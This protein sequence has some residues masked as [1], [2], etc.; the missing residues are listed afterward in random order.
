MKHK[1]ISVWKCKG[2]RATLTDVMGKVA[3]ELG[4]RNCDVSSGRW[5]GG[6]LMSI[7]CAL[8]LPTT[9]TSCS[10]LQCA[11]NYRNKHRRTHI[12][13]TNVYGMHTSKEILILYSL[14]GIINTICKWF[15]WIKYVSFSLP[16]EAFI[17]YSQ[18][19][20]ISSSTVFSAQKNVLLSLYLFS[21]F[22][23]NT[24]TI[25]LFYLII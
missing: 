17:V 3:R 5:G 6:A 16:P 2:E 23:S 15:L 19:I 24:F 20:T 25:M 8:T 1:C 21:N 12:L 10:N 9:V 18:I 7:R 14:W 4:D 13:L 22:L 11:Q